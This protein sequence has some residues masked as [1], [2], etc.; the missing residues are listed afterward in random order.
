MNLCGLVEI[1]AGSEGLE[2]VCLASMQ[3]R[4][5][6]LWLLIVIDVGNNTK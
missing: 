4:E 1:L 3:Y 5:A 2:L 6:C